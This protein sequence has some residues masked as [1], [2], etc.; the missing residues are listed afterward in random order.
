MSETFQKH[1]FYA[2]LIHKVRELLK[3]SRLYLNHAPHF[4]K[5]GLCQELWVKELSI[6]TLVVKCQKKYYNKTTLTEL[7]IAHEQTR[8]LWQIFFDLGYFNYT[9]H[10]KEEDDAKA[11]RRFTA[12]NVKMNEIGRMIG[13]LISN[14]QSEVK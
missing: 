12:I 8:E 6:L 1:S 10:K 13:G 11:F 14:A 2:K 3:L 4:E 9:K 5:Y 7:D